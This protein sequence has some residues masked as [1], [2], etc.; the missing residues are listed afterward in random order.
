[1]VA[2]IVPSR[3]I[4]PQLSCVLI[5][6]NTNRLVATDCEQRIEVECPLAGEGVAML[7]AAKFGQVLA[8]AS[9]ESVSLEERKETLY[10]KAGSSHKLSTQRADEFPGASPVKATVEFSLPCRTMCDAIGSTIF[11]AD[12]GSKRFALNSV[13][14]QCV[15]GTLHLCASDS[16]RV[17]IAN[18]GVAGD[19]ITALIPLKMAKSIK[20]IFTDSPGDMRVAISYNAMRFSCDGIAFQ[21]PQVEGTFPS[22]ASFMPDVRDSLRAEITAGVFLSAM[23]AVAVTNAEESRGVD[24]IRAFDSNGATGDLR[25][26]T[27]TAEIGAS[28]VTIPLAG[29]FAGTCIDGSF[30]TEFLSTLDASSVVECFTC[31]DGACEFRSG[32]VRYVAMPMRKEAT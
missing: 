17:S 30:L 16:R 21:C 19:K 14:M 4:R 7:P 11:A 22:V 2:G 8:V 24:F 27:Q 6:A 13:A 20:R 9:G 15:D 1:L 23:K 25:L 3:P 32:N 18:L 5:D 10:I 31:V 28:E 26:S 29:E 12:E